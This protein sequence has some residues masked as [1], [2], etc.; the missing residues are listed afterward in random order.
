MSPLS[1]RSL[2]RFYERVRVEPAADGDRVL[3]DARPVRTPR[4][5][6]LVVPSALAEAIA[7]EWRAQ[8]KRIVPQSMP[9]TRLACAAID[10][11]R[12]R[13]REVREEVLAYAGSDLLCYRAGSPE[14]LVALQSRHWD[15]VLEWAARELGARLRLAEGVRHIAQPPEALAAIERALAAEDC[16]ALTALHALTTLLGS[17]LLALAHARGRLDADA[18]WAAGHVDEDWQIRQWGE[19]AEA[20]ARRKALRAEFDAATRLLALLRGAS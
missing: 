17:A 4:R 11:V 16:F 8:G 12:G 2:P 9:L 15:P 7:E 20:M 6:E 1:A 19:D 14:G 18:A 5:V 3:L 13:E 10:L